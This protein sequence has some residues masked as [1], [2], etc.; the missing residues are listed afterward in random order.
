MRSS[1][2]ARK[3][4]NF[5]Q[6]ADYVVMP[7]DS[8]AFPLSEDL[9]E[10]KKKRE[11]TSL[12]LDEA[13]KSV[14]AELE[15]DCIQKLCLLHYYMLSNLRSGERPAKLTMIDFEMAQVLALTLQN[16]KQVF[17]GNLNVF[18][19]RSL[20]VGALT[21]NLIA[22]RDGFLG[23]LVQKDPIQRED[24]TAILNLDFQARLQTLAIRHWATPIRMRD[25]ARRLFSAFDKLLIARYG[26][27]S[28]QVLNVLE[29]IE[30]D[31]DK[32]YWQHQ[33]KISAIV[34]AKSKKSALSHYQKHFTD[35]RWDEI[36]QTCKKLK[37]LDQVV[38]LLYMESD[39]FVQA[40]YRVDFPSLSRKF[41]IEESRLKVLVEVHSIEQGELTEKTDEYLFLS[42]PAWKRPFIK[43]KEDFYIPGVHLLSAFAFDMMEHLVLSVDDSCKTQL[44]A[45]RATFLERSI[46]LASKVTFPPPTVHEG[47]TRNTPGETDTLV[48]LDRIAIIIEAKSAKL[49]DSAKRGGKSLLQVIKRNIGKAYSQTSELES[50][51]RSS[52]QT[53]LR[54]SNGTLEDICIEADTIFI[55]LIVMLDPFFSFIADKIVRSNPEF[56]SAIVMGLSD[57]ELIL[58]RLRSPAEIVNYFLK[59]LKVQRTYEMYAADEL[60]F[61]GS[62]LVSGLE[63]PGISPTEVL[64][65]T[66]CSNF[67]IDPRCKNAG[68]YNTELHMLEWWLACITQVEKSPSTIP[69]ELNVVMWSLTFTEQRTIEELRIELVNELVNYKNDEIAKRVIEINGSPFPLKIYLIGIREDFEASMCKINEIII[70][71]P[72]IHEKRRSIALVFD[73]S[74]RS[75]PF[76]KIMWT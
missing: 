6:E 27:D 2:L 69:F 41:N 39:E 65:L 7:L 14:L 43:E 8:D 68:G 45:R 5:E 54:D 51:L 59:R 22:L 62:Y 49:P 47:V 17:T 11:N 31:I 40:I 16:N 52:S 48:M 32:A 25:I 74:S 10:L 75:Y 42:N 72:E 57:F 53:Q 66:S 70:E 63:F 34:N 18:K 21:N 56:R 38:A 55:K 3:S 12:S 23:K 28:T 15:V 60:D 67:I 64:L 19:T 26:L 76:D 37:T 36:Q 73:L 58:E 13:L 4:N 29:A 33:K 50:L 30:Q 1:W 20:D 35:C 61:L 71:S 9:K 24:D 46:V 44:D